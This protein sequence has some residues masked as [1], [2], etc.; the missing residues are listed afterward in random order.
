M[1]VND[2]DCMCIELYF[3]VLNLLFWIEK[4][5]H[6]LFK[7]SQPYKFYNYMF[8]LYFGTKIPKST[9]RLE[10]LQFRTLH[11]E[12]VRTLFRL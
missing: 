8:S 9:I 4:P 7:N 5:N 12:R 1:G 11:L 10:S 2:S 3:S 6:K